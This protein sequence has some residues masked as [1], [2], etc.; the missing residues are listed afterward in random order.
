MGKGY[1]SSNFDIFVQTR[2]IKTKQAWRCRVVVGRL[3]VGKVSEWESMG[4]VVPESRQFCGN[5]TVE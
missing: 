4:I 1:G 5:R 3:E 2:R